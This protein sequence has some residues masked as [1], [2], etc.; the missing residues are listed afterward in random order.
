MTFFPNRENVYPMVAAAA[1]DCV[2]VSTT[3]GRLKDGPDEGCFM[4]S[5]ITVAVA[6][7]PIATATFARKDARGVVDS[8]STASI[9]S[10]TSSPP[11]EGSAPDTDAFVVRETKQDKLH[12]LFLLMRPRAA[13]AGKAA[14]RLGRGR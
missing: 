2:E 13:P 14:R 4:K 8:T 5:E 9:I 12:K 7:T 6:A 10:F 1:S 11:A 3:C